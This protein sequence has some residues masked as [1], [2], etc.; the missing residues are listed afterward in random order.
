MTSKIP[1]DA[2]EGLMKKAFIDEQIGPELFWDALLNAEL[3]VPVAEDVESSNPGQFPMLL[4]QDADGEDVIWLFTSPAT[5]K[6]YT[7]QDLKFIELAATTVFSKIRSLEH[8]VLLIGPQSLTLSMHP[9]LIDSLAEGK[10]PDFQLNT[11][12]IVEGPETKNVLQVS[13]PLDETD[14]LEESFI[15]V[16]EELPQVLEAAF[17]QVVDRI[18][19]RLLLG[20]KMETES[21]DAL[22]N[23]AEHVAKAAEGVLKKGKSMDITLMNGS[24]KEAFEKWGKVFYLKS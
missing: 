20:L 10:V 16:F 6:A 22:R 21:R 17:V 12:E 7:E 13:S 8:E 9:D 3:T 4:G 14:E 23:V 5:M 15:K 2:I 11:G 19:S 24:L 1:S 18:G